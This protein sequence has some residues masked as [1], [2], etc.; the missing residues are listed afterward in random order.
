MACNFDFLDTIE[1][2]IIKREKT[3]TSIDT[4]N[5]TLSNENDHILLVN[6]RSMNKNFGNLKILIQSILN[7]PS[8]IICTETFNEV[9]YKEY[10]LNDYDSYYNESRINGNNGVI[11][12]VNKNI[13]QVTKTIESGKIKIINTKITLNKGDSLDISSIYRYTVYQSLNLF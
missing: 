13:R 6:I 2:D 12:F 5:K 7:K 8:I 4:L 10:D 3:F 1:K 9:N 11:F